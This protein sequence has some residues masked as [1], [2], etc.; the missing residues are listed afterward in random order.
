MHHY[1]EFLETGTQMLTLD[2]ESPQAIPTIMGN[3]T[4]LYD[5]S[6]DVHPTLQQ[7]IENHTELFSKQL[8]KTSVNPHVIDNGD[9]SPV[10]VSQCTI[11]FHYA[12]IVHRQLHEMAPIN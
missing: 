3:A 9:A 12:E 11:L 6:T 1:V 2:D 10:R 7:L 4:I 8:G 5:M